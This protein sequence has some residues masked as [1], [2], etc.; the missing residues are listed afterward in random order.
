[1]DQCIPLTQIKRGYP[2]T[3]FYSI[4]IIMYCPIIVTL[5]AIVIAAFVATKQAA[6]NTSN[7]LILC[8]CFADLINGAT[9]MPL[10]V[11][12]LHNIDRKDSCII[13]KLLFTVGGTL[14]NASAMLTSLIA[15][16]RFLHMN[17]NIQ[18]QP[19]LL[20]RIFKSSNIVYIVIIVSIIGFTS[21][22]LG[23]ILP[24]SQS[25]M[26]ILLGPFAVFGIAVYVSLV[27]CL[28][29]VGYK[30]ISNFTIENPVYHESGEQPEYIK[31]LYKTVLILVLL[32]CVSF[33]PYCLAQGVTY[34]LLITKVPLSLT[35]RAY[36]TEISGLI[37]H[38]NYFTNCL[39][40]LYFNKKAKVWILRKFKI[41]ATADDNQ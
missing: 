10:F 29:V 38:A 3:L 16:D 5:N 24:T 11:Y 40:V 30:R 33:L 31:N 41:S 26:M 13:A 20:R 27:T 22:G 6:K 25:A 39:V 7:L 35:T 8:V 34:I 14:G 32:V 1:M 18:N 37:I 19:S 36:F 2:H 9:I 15:V 4:I 23:T 12:L 21:S 28:Y 17:P